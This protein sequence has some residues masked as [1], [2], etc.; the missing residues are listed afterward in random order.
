MPK[1]IPM[2][3][4]IGCGICTD[5]KMLIRV[6][7]LPEGG[8]ILDPAGKMNGRGAYL[9]RNPQ[10]L[11]KAI[12]RKA[13]ARAFRAEVTKEI[14]EHLTEELREYLKEGTG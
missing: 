6:V 10:C 5:K 2:R 11:E 3:T 1:K 14:A 8:A 7:R 12:K 4:C 9:C 13:L